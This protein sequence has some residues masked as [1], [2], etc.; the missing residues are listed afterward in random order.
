VSA[1]QILDAFLSRLFMHCDP[2]PYPS[3]PILQKLQSLQLKNCRAVGDS[4]VAALQRAQNL[5]TLDLIGTFDFSF[6]GLA[7]LGESSSLER[8]TL[9]LS[10]SEEDVD[11]FL[12]PYS[13]VP[14]D[15]TETLN[16]VA[17]CPQ[18]KQL[19]LGNT[20]RS[21]GLPARWGSLEHLEVSL[22]MLTRNLADV[23]AFA[24][25]CRT[26]RVLEI[27]SDSQGSPSNSEG[28]EVLKRIGWACPQSLE[29]LSIQ[30]NK[31][32]PS[33]VEALSNCL[34]LSSLRIS[35]TA[36]TSRGIAYL[37]ARTGKLTELSL[38][39]SQ[40][41]RG[42][43][44]D[45]V[46]AIAQA[47]PSLRRLDLTRC[48]SLSDIG[49]AS[50]ATC[51][52]LEALNLSHTSV[53]DVGLVTIVNSIPGLEEINLDG[54][55][56]INNLSPITWLPELKSLSLRHC[57]NAVTD[58]LVGELVTRCKKLR[59]LYLD[60]CRRLTDGAFVSIASSRSIRILS[61][62]ECGSLEGG[63]WELA[64]SSVSWFTK[65]LISLDVLNCKGADLFRNQGILEIQR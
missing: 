13:I 52:K 20:V 23:K 57:E 15:I 58:D 48:T 62:R 4:A 26:L 59:E 61:I 55:E 9:D 7:C 44:D 10:R 31:V 53:G 25:A 39:S 6:S 37:A 38:A 8:L 47:A 45:G 12:P 18:L 49:F 11:V 14:F 3:L 43:S 2:A 16:A 41:V 51:A 33:A 63:L 40:P 17:G 27:R 65:V 36:V 1:D 34:N 50:L 42:V 29:K 64:T 35:S 19:R 28:G 54:C 24:K 56:N 5:K 32:D 21:R 22:G 60:E 46:Q 30:C